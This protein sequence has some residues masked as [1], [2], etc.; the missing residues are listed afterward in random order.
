[1]KK[2]KITAVSYLNTK[3]LLY[4]LLNSEIADQIELQLDIPSRC[5]EKLQNDEVDLGLV[6]VAI[7]PHLQSPRIV[8]DY[9]IGTVGAVKTVS[10]FSEQPI[11]QLSAIYLDYHSRTS[12]ELTKLLVQNHW[13]VDLKFIP[14][15]TGYETKIGGRTGGLVIGDRT[16]GMEDKFPYVYDLGLEWERFSG[17]PFVFAAWVSN[18]KLDERF[19]KKF[20]RALGKGLDAIPK[21]M[22]LLPTPSSNFDLEAYFTRYISY[23]LDEPKKKGLAQ[24]LAAISPQLQPSLEASLV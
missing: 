5:A 22:Y 10:I 6:P 21:L 16:I 19:L 14:A 8:S 3:P 7:I 12:V 15:T 18:K 2:I 13:K 24:F 1:M 23:E 9:C 4:G 20:N 11:E 17:L